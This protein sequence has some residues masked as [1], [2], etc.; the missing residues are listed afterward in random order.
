MLKSRKYW[1]KSKRTG[2]S[3]VNKYSFSFLNSFF[4][5]VTVNENSD[6]KY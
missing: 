6:G 3:N 4:Q 1:K 2:A 5:K